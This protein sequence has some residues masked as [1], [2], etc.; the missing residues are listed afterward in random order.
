MLHFRNV[1]K[2]FPRVLSGPSSAD[3]DIELDPGFASFYKW[4]LKNNVPIIILSSGMEPMIRALLGKLVGPQAETIPI[5]SN[6]VNINGDGSWN[7][8][9]RDE[10]RNLASCLVDIRFWTRQI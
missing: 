5:I 8:V 9:F 3:R 7:I 6:G 10:S 2:R 4:T 1:S